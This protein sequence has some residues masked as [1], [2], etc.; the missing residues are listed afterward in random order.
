MTP[1]EREFLLQDLDHSREA[2][3]R[4]VDGLNAATIREYREAA[5]PLDRR[6]M[7]RAHRRSRIRHDALAGKRAGR[8]QQAA[9]RPETGP[10]RTTRCA[11]PHAPNRASCRFEAPETILPTEGRWPL[12]ELVPQFES[13]RKRTR[14]ALSSPATT[15][16]V[17]ARSRILNLACS[18]ATQW[19]LL[20]AHHCDRHRAQIEKIKSS[21]T[22][23]R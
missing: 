6:R 5:G 15:I 12:A 18:I 8:R 9:A 14:A 2:L 3:L 21:P 13:A 16:C 1:A 11:E 4:T 17:A 19:L 23:P 7:P 22:F 20:I 10:A